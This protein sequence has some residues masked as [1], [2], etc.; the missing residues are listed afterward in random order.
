[1]KNVDHLSSFVFLVIMA[2]AFICAFAIIGVTFS[3]NPSSFDPIGA[4]KD[5]IAFAKWKKQMLKDMN[6]L[7]EKLHS[8]RIRNLKEWR[9]D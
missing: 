3:N 4:I 5:K 2:C 8:D 6:A 9:A 7:E 1:M